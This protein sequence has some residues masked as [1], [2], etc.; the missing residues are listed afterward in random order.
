LC[1]LVDTSYSVHIKI[2]SK[3]K[4]LIPKKNFGGIIYKIEKNKNIDPL[5]G[6]YL[7]RVI[8]EEN[9]S[10]RLSPRKDIFTLFT[11]II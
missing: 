5:Y 7:R 6:G 10:R 3:H 4:I 11:L 2:V 1:I 8:Y 9:V